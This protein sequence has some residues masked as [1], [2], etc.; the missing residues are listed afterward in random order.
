MRVVVLGANGQLGR[1]LT[2]R[3]PLLGHAV[4]PLGRAEADVAD[5]SVV[6]SLAALT[7]DAIVNAAAMTNVDGAERDPETA[8]RINGQGA[9]NAARAAARARAVL[10][11]VSTDY[12]F[13]GLGDA[14]YAEDAPTNPIS[15]YGASKLDG[16]RRALAAWNRVQIARTAWLYGLGG[17]NFVTRILQLADE[18]GALSVVTTETGNPTFCD[19]LAD[20]I[21][22]LIGL[23]DYGVF[24][25][26]NEGYASRYDFARAILAL[27]G[28]H[29]P[30]TP[31]DSFARA[32]RPPAFAPLANRRA[33]A[34]G[35]TLRPW[36]DALAAY[37]A[38]EPA[39]ARQE[40][41]L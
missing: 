14:P 26:V 32:A 23:P 25:L 2:R 28:R 12:V 40:R 34:L 33:A 17:R 21:G 9:E 6:E 5:P 30:I 41:L 7:P 29:S 4:V 38:A 24:H 27:A 16:E 31:A 10:V 18:R 37:I 20:A 15:V 8:F 39:L 35:V 36:Q 1:A 13:D 11:Q 19:D 3:L 22:R